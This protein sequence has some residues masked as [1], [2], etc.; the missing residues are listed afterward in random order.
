MLTFFF[1]RSLCSAAPTLIAAVAAAV[2][3]VIV[4]DDIVVV[5]PRFFPIRRSA[6]LFFPHFS[7]FRPCFFVCVLCMLHA[8]PCVC[9][10][11]SVFGPVKTS[12]FVV[13]VDG[14]VSQMSVADRASADQRTTECT[15]RATKWP[16]AHAHKR[17]AIAHPFRN[18][19]TNAPDT[20]DGRSNRSAEKNPCTPCTSAASGKTT[21]TYG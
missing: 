19:V 3:I 12:K 4:A 16:R 18:T 2:V 10:C 11:E 6:L 13:Y 8:F 17:T 15:Q 9:V 20:T 5:A 21:K 14:R 7:L 1:A